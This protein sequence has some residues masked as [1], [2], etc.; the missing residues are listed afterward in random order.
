MGKSNHRRSERGW[1][2]RMTREN[3]ACESLADRQVIGER[4]GES[5]S[6]IGES[7]LR[8]NRRGV[9]DIGRNSIRYR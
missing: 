6:K 5:E 8:L 3:R 1:L 9:V 2:A 7:P 4:A